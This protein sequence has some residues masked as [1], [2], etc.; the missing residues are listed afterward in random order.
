MSANN[1]K[2]DYEI[3][4][5]LIFNHLWK[6][7]SILISFILISFFISTCFI[8]I[9]KPKYESNIFLTPDTISPFY[10]LDEHFIDFEKLFYSDKIF[11]DWKKNNSQS[12]L[13]YDLLKNTNTIDGVL[14]SNNDTNNFITIN[15]DL[16]SIKSKDVFILNDIYEYLNFVNLNLNNI[17][18]T[19]ANNDLEI[20]NNIFNEKNFE[21]E[22]S[23]GNILNLERFILEIKNGS[24]IFIVDRPLTPYKTSINNILVYL[25]SF[26]ICTFFGVLL[27]FIRSYK[28][29]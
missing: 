24:N 9:Q 8:F 29:N 7:K 22:I 11:N 18:L 23:I 6:N 15:K 3:D 10:N 2:N 26:F 19:Q 21:N 17:Y 12:S 14:F 1:I 25:I 20:L 5:I 16:I 13:S 27:V 4:L 28:N